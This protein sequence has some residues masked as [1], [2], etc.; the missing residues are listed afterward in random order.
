MGRSSSDAWLD[1]PTC[2]H[3]SKD[4]KKHRDVVSRF[5]LEAQ[6]G[7]QS[8]RMKKLVVVYLEMGAMSAAFRASGRCPGPRRLL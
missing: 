2:K 5:L 7:L 4:N 3:P 1:L 8:N 6:G